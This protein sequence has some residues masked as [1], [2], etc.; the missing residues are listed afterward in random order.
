MTALGAAETV[1]IIDDDEAVR[2]SLRLLL[3]AHAMIVRDFA[4]VP[5]FLAG[6]EPRPRGCL[7]LD[8]HLPVFSGFDFL[9]RHS[10]RIDE[11]PVVML[12]GR[13]DPGTRAK[14][15]EA[16]VAEFLEKPVADDR[17]IAAVRRALA[18][19]ATL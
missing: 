11:L 10:N 14:A 1:F 8:L 12:T 18:Q 5:E 3:E 17:L 15:F 16:G 19:I 2:D 9:R 4:S 6:T 13:C 7:I